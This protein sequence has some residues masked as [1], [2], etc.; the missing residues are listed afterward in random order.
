MKIAENF[1]KI[2]PIVAKPREG[3]ELMVSEVLLPK[4]LALGVLLQE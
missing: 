1:S 3:R 4:E 2:N